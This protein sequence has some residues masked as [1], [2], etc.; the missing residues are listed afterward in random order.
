MSPYSGETIKSTPI[1]FLK[2]KPGVRSYII[3]IIQAISPKPHF[4]ENFAGSF[5]NRD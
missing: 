5:G 1:F 2:I 3:P 4:N